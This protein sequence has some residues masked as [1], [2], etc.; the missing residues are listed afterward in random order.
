MP[1]RFDTATRRLSLDPRDPAFYRDPYA[2]YATVLAQSP[3]A[4][5]E[6]IG[7]WCFFSFEH[8]NRLLRDRRFGREILHV[9][10]REEL[11]IPE[12]RPHTRHFDEVDAHSLLEREPPVHTRL[13]APISRAF[14][15]RRVEALRPAIESMANE[16][17]DAFPGEP[18]DL[19]TYYATPI[20]VRIIARMLGVPEALAPQLLAWS[21]DMVAMYGVGRSHAVE[22]RADAAAAEFSQ[23]IRRLVA[24]RRAH[25]GD[26]LL[27]VLIAAEEQG[28][29]LSEAEL[30]STAILLLNAGHEATVHALGNAV[31]AVLRHG[32]AMEVIVHDDTAM[33]RLVEE[34]LRFVPPLHLF[35]RFVLTDL[36]ESG[37]ALR[38]G[39]QIAL[40]LGATGHDPRVQDAPDAFLPDRPQPQHTSFG[41]GIHFCVGAPLARLELQ[42]ALRVLFTRCPTLQLAGS[43][44]PK[45]SW[46]FHGLDALFVQA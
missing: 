23:Y 33:A 32:V 19:L 42:C 9:A 18:F 25:P 46:H 14:V 5:W 45:D 17:V 27:S 43:P 41:A 44:Q 35:K 3:V 34:S 40:V 11:G 29:T 22:T 30:V 1:M 6:E 38:K 36:E 7:C 20:P 37:I 24:E 13:R 15:S 10:T 28:E 16:L 2:A 12:P 26:D 31:H 4:F 21:H 39:D 8:V